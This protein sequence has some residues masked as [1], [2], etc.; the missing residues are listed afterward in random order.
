M[1]FF[2]KLFSQIV[3]QS[4]MISK[5]IDLQVRMCGNESN[6]RLNKYYLLGSIQ[7]FKLQDNFILGF[8]KLF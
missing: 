1:N 7:C 2:W 6:S 5:D 4:T 8:S 3:A